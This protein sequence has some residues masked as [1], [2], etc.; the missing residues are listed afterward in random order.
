MTYS[1]TKYRVLG[2]ITFPLS[3]ASCAP[4]FERFNCVFRVVG[5][6]VFKVY[7]IQVKFRGSYRG[8]S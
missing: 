7:W 1:A 5:F 3:A 6:K 2:R 4:F 8:L